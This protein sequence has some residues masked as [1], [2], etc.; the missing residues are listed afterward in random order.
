MKRYYIFV[1]HIIVPFRIFIIIIIRMVFVGNSIRTVF[2][3]CNG[4]ILLRSEI[5]IDNYSQN[6][7]INQINKSKYRLQIR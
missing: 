4:I 5:G 7:T 1:Y 2:I 6:K 3:E